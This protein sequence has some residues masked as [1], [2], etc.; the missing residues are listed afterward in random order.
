VADDFALSF[1]CPKMSHVL[2]SCTKTKEYGTRF[3]FSGQLG[4]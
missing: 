2:F 3:I 4:T 1:L